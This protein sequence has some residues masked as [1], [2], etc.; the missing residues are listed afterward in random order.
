M[1]N[2]LFEVEKACNRLNILE[3]EDQEFEYEKEALIQNPYEGEVTKYCMVG[4]F[5]TDNRIPFEVMSDTLSNLWK[6]GKGVCIK[7]ISNNRFSFQFFHEIDF[8]RIVEGGPWTFKNHLLVWREVAKGM[9]LSTVELSST[10]FWVQI[11]DV[12]M[13]FQSERVCKDVGNFVGSYEYSDPRNLDGNPR[14]F[15]RVRA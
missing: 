8:K 15:L 10:S 5:L 3:E 2:P 13:G 6:P 4:A 11:H 7:K 14:S 9:D 12:P 1:E